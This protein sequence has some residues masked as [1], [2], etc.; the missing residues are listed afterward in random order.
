MKFRKRPIELEAEQFFPHRFPW[1]AGVVIRRHDLPGSVEQISPDYCIWN[2]RANVW[3][4]VYPGD[5]IITGIRGCRYPCRADVFTEIYD[6]VSDK[7]PGPP[8]DPR[9]W[10]GVDLDG[11]LAQFDKWRGMAHIGEPV[12]L[13]LERVKRWLDAGKDV[14]I[15]T[16]RCH[17]SSVEWDFGGAAVLDAWMDTHIG[18]RLRVTCE[19]DG[20]MLQ[21][22]D[23][24]AFQIITNTGQ[25]VDGGL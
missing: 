6:P 18:R 22:W 11:T 15:F 3:Q 24:R 2:E 14:R 7:G 16:S 23:D 20:W 12:P 19:K 21:I 17:P 1:P 4:Q 10:I 8:A 5:W 9:H 13:M 25:R